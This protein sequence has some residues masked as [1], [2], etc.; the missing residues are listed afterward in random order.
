MGVETLLACLLVLQD[1][2]D[3]LSDAVRETRLADAKAALADLAAGDGARA[4]RALIHALPR[5]RERTAALLSAT[6]RARL[7][8]HRADTSFS[9]G[10]AEDRIK[11][12]QMQEARA[13]IRET[14]RRAVE[15]ELVYEAVR[16]AF[17][18]LPPEAAPV[19]A[20]EAARTGSWLLRCEL[21]E[22]LGA[23]GAREPLLAALER[24]KDPAP[25][26]AALHG[27][28]GA[29]RAADFLAHPHWQV[30]LEALRAVRD[31]REAVGP[32]IEGLSSADAR[33]RHAAVDTLRALTRTDL[34]A[35]PDVWQDWWKANREDFD[36]GRYRP[37]QPRRL[38]GPSRTTFYEIPVVSTRVCFVIDRSLSMRE[39]GRFDA[40][41]RELKRLLGELP[42]GARV[43][44]LFFGESTS[45]FTRSTRPLDRACRRDAADFIDRQLYESWTDLHGA[46]EKA[47]ALSGNPETGF[48]REDGVD[49][50]FVLSDGEATIGRVVDG[51]LVARVTARRARYLRPVIHTVALSSEA[52]SLKLLAELTG[53]E[54]RRR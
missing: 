45:A 20:A 40:A 15:G 38:P 1:P 18:A 49:T 21:L 8:H 6:L 27:L 53:G 11:E 34:P 50:I 33:F 13:R 12:R 54:H 24:E 41:K 31:S 2:R 26:A 16:E 22:G 23:M 37:D 19:L 35:D 4:A 44:I 32:L 7:D 17:A 51:E 46:L 14:S 52:K 25:L 39:E 28:A 47:L 3:R 9:Y 5:A 42:D 36:S 30:R 48:L 29:P 43:N 10:L